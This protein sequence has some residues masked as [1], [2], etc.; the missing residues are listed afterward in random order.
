[1]TRAIIS[2]HVGVVKAALEQLCRAAQ[3]VVRASGGRV[4]SGVDTSGPLP[5]PVLKR[6]T[7]GDISFVL[8]DYTAERLA[9]GRPAWV[10]RSIWRRPDACELQNSIPGRISVPG[11]QMA[12]KE[13]M[14]RL[15][16]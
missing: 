2:C 12:T 6:L 3:G 10:W 14:E 5:M 8:L 7:W 13:T 9:F 11:M 15:E 4:G 1:M 16:H